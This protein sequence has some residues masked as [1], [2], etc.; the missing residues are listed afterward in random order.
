MMLSKIASAGSLA[1]AGEHALQHGAQFLSFQV[2]NKQRT[3][4]L[5]SWKDIL[6][7]EVLRYRALIYSR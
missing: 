3:R 6:N 5:R 1:L 2:N 4:C 7:D